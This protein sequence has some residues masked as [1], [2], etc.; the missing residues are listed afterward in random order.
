MGRILRS[1]GAFLEHATQTNVE[2]WRLSGQEMMLP[3]ML[4]DRRK[5]LDQAWNFRSRYAGRMSTVALSAFSLSS[6]R[7]SLTAMAARQPGRFQ[8]VVAGDASAHTL[9]PTITRGPCG[10]GRVER[11]WGSQSLGRSRILPDDQDSVRR[12]TTRV[13]KRW[14]QSRVI[15]GPGPLEHRRWLWTVRRKTCRAKSCP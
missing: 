13:A 11:T 2:P 5:E 15:K 14:K 3:E 8:I 9:N 10:R 7:L 4:C 12:P 6:V 1:R